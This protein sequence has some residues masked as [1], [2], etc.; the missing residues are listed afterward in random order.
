MIVTIDGPSGTG[1]ST[2]ARKIAEEL[3]FDYLDSGAMYRCLSLKILREKIDPLDLESIEMYTKSISHAL[4]V[5]N[6]SLDQ[7][8][9]PV[10]VGIRIHARYASVPEDAG[11]QKNVLEWLLS[12]KVRVAFDPFEIYIR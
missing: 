7:D 6:A 5:Q 4:V 8:G 10:D 11:L 3:K 1:K 9:V 2:V 12:D